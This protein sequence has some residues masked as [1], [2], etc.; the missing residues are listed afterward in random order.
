MQAQ[1]NRDNM[2]R[3]F[4]RLP[5]WVLVS[6]ILGCFPIYMVVGTVIQGLPETW[7]SYKYEIKFA[8]EVNKEW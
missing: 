7:K 3:I 6:M 1:T 8:L 5:R 2:K 4:K